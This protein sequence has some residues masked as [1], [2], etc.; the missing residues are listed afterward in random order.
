MTNPHTDDLVEIHELGQ[1]DRDCP[2][3]AEQ[4]PTD[5]DMRDAAGDLAFHEWREE[6]DG[7]S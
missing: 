3:C 2:V 7:P 1:C 6:H 5:T 4:R